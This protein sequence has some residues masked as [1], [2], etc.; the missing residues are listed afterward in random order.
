MSGVMKRRDLPQPPPGTPLPEPEP[1]LADMDRFHEIA[2]SGQLAEIIYR[3]AGC[4]VVPFKPK[5]KSPDHP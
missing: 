1:N 2:A 5:A 3:L 4:N